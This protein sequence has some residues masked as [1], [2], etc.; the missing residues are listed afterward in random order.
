MVKCHSNDTVHG[1]R[2]GRRALANGNSTPP[3]YQINTPSKVR[4]NRSLCYLIPNLAFTS[5][6]TSTLCWSLTNGIGV[7]LR[8]NM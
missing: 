3:D 6:V 5:A 1:K 2:I 4:R 7:W 8:S